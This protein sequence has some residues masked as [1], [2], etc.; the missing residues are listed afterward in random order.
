MTVSPVAVIPPGM[1]TTMVVV[2]AEI[3]PI[4]DVG[5]FEA[6]MS[7]P[8]LTVDRVETPQLVEPESGIVTPTALGERILNGME[9][10]RV[11]YQEGMARI[12]GTVR[13]DD[14]RLPDFMRLF[15]DT[16]HMS[17]Q[18]DMLGKMV[19]RTTQNLDQL[20]KGQ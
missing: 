19:G 8:R 18:Q 10:M 9:R 2:P 3:A 16:M 13:K 17:I 5:R 14:M 6:A 4:D 7:A 12:D 20:L 15:V 1:T 11:S